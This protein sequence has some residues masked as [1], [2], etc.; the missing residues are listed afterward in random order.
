MSFT[1]RENRENHSSEDGGTG[2]GNTIFSFIRSFVRT[3][4]EDFTSEPL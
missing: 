1:P 2:N 4:R 3:I